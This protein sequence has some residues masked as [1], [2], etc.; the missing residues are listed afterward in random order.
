MGASSVI[1]SDIDAVD[2]YYTGLDKALSIP[3]TE[4]RLFGKPEAINRRRMGVAIATS[5]TVDDALKKVVDAA[6]LV[7]IH[8]TNRNN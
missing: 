2:F 7:D 6:D 5:G 3:D 4:I 8:A 1:L